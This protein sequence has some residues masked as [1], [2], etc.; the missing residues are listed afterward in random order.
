MDREPFGN[1]RLKIILLNVWTFVCLNVTCD[2]IED[3]LLC[4][5]SVIIMLVATVLG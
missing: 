5:G 3:A 2:V 1:G 4:T